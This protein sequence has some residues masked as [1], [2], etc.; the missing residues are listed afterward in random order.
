VYGYNR[1]AFGWQHVGYRTWWHPDHGYL[2]APSPST[3]CAYCDAVGGLLDAIAALSATLQHQKQAQ[4]SKDT[5]FLEEQRTSP[6]YGLGPGDSAPTGS[7]ASDVWNAQMRHAN[8]TMNVVP[9]S[10]IVPQYR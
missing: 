4:A 8:A 5:K 10:A 2:N 7:W 3:G 1:S 9:V 6:G